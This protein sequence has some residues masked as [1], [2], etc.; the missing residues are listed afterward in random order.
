MVSGSSRRNNLST[1]PGCEAV[2]V[3]VA[4]RL[5]C[6]ACASA[7]N[8]NAMQAA[9]LTEAFSGQAYTDPFCS[10][11]RIHGGGFGAMTRSLK[12]AVMT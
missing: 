6:C 4:A 2:G 1:K 10:A 5:L 9:I 12:A 11:M 8:D 7:E 3:V